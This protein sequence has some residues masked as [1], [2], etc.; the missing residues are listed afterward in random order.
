MIAENIVQG[1]WLE[2]ND[3]DVLLIGQEMADSLE[4]GIGDRVTLV[5][6]ATRR[7]ATAR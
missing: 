5:G 2:A 1:R 7:C 3:E 6:R 4:V